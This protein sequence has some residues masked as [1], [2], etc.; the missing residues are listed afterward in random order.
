MPGKCHF[1]RLLALWFGLI[2]LLTSCVAEFVNPI[3]PPKSSEPDQA[4][5]GEW[6]MAEKDEKM[7]LYIYP[8]RSGWIDII[9]VEI[10]SKNKIKLDIYEGYTT[11]IQQEKFLC[12]KE[13][14]MV[15]KKGEGEESGYYIVPYKISDDGRFSF[16]IFDVDR[17][18]DMI[19]KGELKGNIIRWKTIVTSGA[20][21]LVSLILKKGVDSFVD[22][23]Q[24]ISKS[25]FSRPKK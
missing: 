11:Q 15:V 16:K 22:T 12:L 18:N 24:D 1:F 5:L 25:T 13:R 2:P 21:E 8:R 17:V 14:E 23:T 3:P 20:D 10:D 4:I 6:E 9:S 19:R 7:R